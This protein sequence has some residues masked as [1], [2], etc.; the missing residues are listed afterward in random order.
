MGRS[1]VTK[2]SH[3]AIKWRFYAARERCTCPKN[4]AFPRYGG[5]G[6]TFSFESGQQFNDWAVENGFQPGLY[7][8]RIDNDGPYSPENCRF[9]TL[10]ESNANKSDTR[11]IDGKSMSEWARELGVT[12]QCI[13]QRIKK[14]MK[15]EDAVRLLSTPNGAAR[16]AGLPN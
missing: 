16:R 14:G 11:I 12:V 9:V 5:R 4:K 6:I 10:A 13:S 1:Q 3:P 8:D 15:P 7:L 2:W